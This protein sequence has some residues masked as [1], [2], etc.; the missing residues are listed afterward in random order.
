MNVVLDLARLDQW[1]SL[2]P[3]FGRHAGIVLC[4]APVA[5]PASSRVESTYDLLGFCVC[6]SRSGRA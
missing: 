3:I 5:E 1:G 2:C 4:R 6:G